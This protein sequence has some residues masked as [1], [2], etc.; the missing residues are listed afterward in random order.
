MKTLFITSIYANLWG[1]EFG[2]RPSREHH[3]RL[4]LL[5]ILN[6]N[7]TKVVCFTSSEEI[8]LLKS[9]F[10]KDNGVS[11]EKLE[12]VVFDLTNSKYFDLIHSKKNLEKIKKSERCFK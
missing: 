3:Y 7:P 2:G 5:N 1:T 12:L 11:K 6:T 10:Y 9:F 8:E 4:S